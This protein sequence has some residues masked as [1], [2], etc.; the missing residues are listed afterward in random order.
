MTYTSL[1]W[2]QFLPRVVNAPVSI[3]GAFVFGAVIDGGTRVV[4][5]EDCYFES[6]NVSR[7]NSQIGSSGSKAKTGT[8]ALSVTSLT[9]PINP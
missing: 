7:T 5:C 2:P 9:T 3:T 4:A 1:G 6:A 8:S